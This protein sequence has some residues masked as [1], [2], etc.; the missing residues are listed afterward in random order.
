M[1]FLGGGDLQTLINKY[2]I[3]P[4]IMKLF[5][6]EMVMALDYLHSK[7]ILHRDIKPENILI[8]NNVNKLNLTEY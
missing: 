5:V 1:E 2:S 4:Y 3:N 7:N 8:S 6:A